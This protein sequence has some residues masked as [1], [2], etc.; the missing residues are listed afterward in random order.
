MAGNKEAKLNLVISAQDEA[1]SVIESLANSLK[2][3]FDEI[4]AAMTEAFSGKELESF[5]T[6]LTEVRETVAGLGSQT[7]EEK[8]VME[9]AFGTMAR[10]VSTDSDDMLKSIKSVTSDMKSM[11]EDMSALGRDA[12]EQ[13]GN[14][15]KAFVNMSSTFSDTSQNIN[16]AIRTITGGMNDLESS[17]RSLSSGMDE[18]TNSSSRAFDELASTISDDV[19]TI[20]SS[21]QTMGDG[22]QTVRSELNDLKTTA[23]ETGQGIKESLDFM[24]LQLAGQM[25]EGVGQK[26]TGFFGEAISSAVNFD[27]EIT[28]TAASL[29]SNLPEGIKLSTKQIQAMTDEALKLGNTGFFSANQ[30]SEAM[31]VMA[32][33]GI[34]YTHIM[35]GGIQTVSSVA[36]ANQQDLG[37]TAN[38]VSDIIH[39]MGD[40]LTKEFGPSTQKQLGAVGDA[41][42]AALHHARIS[43]EDFLN[44][45][46]YVGPQASAAGISFRDVAAG[47][48]LLGQ[49]G[50]KSSQAGTTLRR[51]LTNLTPASKAAAD[52]M[53]QLGMTTKNGGNIFYDAT[54]HMKPLVQV[55]QLLH[56]KIAGLTPQMQQL[57]LKTIFGQYALSGM[58]IVA[59]TAPAKFAALEKSMGKI[60]VTAE[61]V[62]EKS[63]GWGMQVQALNSHFG[64]FMKE[65]GESLKPVMLPL[66]QILNHLMD[67]WEK[68][69]KHFHQIV[70]VIGLAAGAFLMLG[71]ALLSIIGTVGIFATS[72]AAGL[73]VLGAIATPAG[74]VIGAIAAIT[75][76]VIGFKMLW[77]HD[78]GGI[79]EKTTA[80]WDAV[81]TAFDVSLD[82]IGK[83]VQS[84]VKVVTEWWGK[85]SPDFQKAMDNIKS[86]M[87]FF[88]PLWKADW[89]NIKTITQFA[90]TAIKT[91]ITTILNVIKAIIQGVWT[92]ITEI[93]KG[94]FEVI[95]GI[96]QAFVHLISFQWGSFGK[97]LERIFTGVGTILGSI[98]KGMDVALRGI[99]QALWSG[100]KSIFSAGMSAVTTIWKNG[101]NGVKSFFDPIISAIK[102]AAETLWNDVKNAF[103]QG[104]A[105]AISTVKNLASSIE[106]TLAALPGEALQWGENMINMFIQGIESKI[107]AVGNAIK[108]VANTVKSFLGFHSPTEKGPASD[109]DQ[110]MPNMMKMFTSGVED[111]T[112]TLQAAIGKVALGLQTSFTQTHQNVQN[113]VANPHVNIPASP[114]SNGFHIQNLNISVDGR[115]SKTTD[116]LAEKIATKF[117]QQMPMVLSR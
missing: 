47:I 16:D 9:E 108:G 23:E 84:A 58:T 18:S 100:T 48:A 89:D 33:Q 49:H 97:D 52:M 107:S 50:I 29:N 103:S 99:F 35:S 76:A 83:T 42:T 63:Q 60:G 62:K 69:G 94:T 13:A 92:T 91:D 25:I 113:I 101:W 56:D 64:T 15:A 96:F 79:Q 41:M 3:S 95:T 106:S 111:H 24:N 115:S 82:F 71:G 114:S 14:S 59:E 28:N 45:M 34:D 4:K 30:I 55:Q 77:D 85:I 7:M 12:E 53:N 22:L 104:T 11:G 110:W 70:A 87:K 8:A 54:G 51:M 80:V 112:P 72:F 86:I 88:A 67:L 90:W 43:M 61:I 32:K 109:S 21:I 2:E 57:A 40:S 27:Q 6:A 117:R 5:K 20:A 93:F 26:I 68:L 38:V 105:A 66:I 75:A 17:T 98:A 36:A 1:K 19:Q 116:E 78:I 74:I 37:E 10:A 31:N 65:I 81:K 39:E 44:T 46:K 102:Q 73:E